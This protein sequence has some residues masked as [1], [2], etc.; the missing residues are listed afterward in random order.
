MPNEGFLHGDIVETK[1]AEEWS[2][3]EAGK[4]CLTTF[5][6]LVLILAGKRE[7]L[8]ST[9]QYSTDIQGNPLAS[10]KQLSSN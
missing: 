9:P 8:S 2:D 7:Q 3:V 10:K 4:V 5:G 1:G 6:A